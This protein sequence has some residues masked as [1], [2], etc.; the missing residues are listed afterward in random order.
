MIS[1]PV[2]GIIIAAPMPWRPRAAM[3]LGL[4]L[5][6]GRSA[7]EASTNSAVPGAERPLGAE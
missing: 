5:R 4:A 2:E 6:R 1:E 3:I 7:A